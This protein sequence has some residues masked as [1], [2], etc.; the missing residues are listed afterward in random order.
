[1]LTSALVQGVLRAWLGLWLRLA[2]SVAPDVHGTV[3]VC[4]VLL[5]QGLCK[6]EA[7]VTGC[8]RASAAHAE[9]S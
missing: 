2:R 1:M 5:T 3:R 9:W 8:V 4:R 6:S 7:S